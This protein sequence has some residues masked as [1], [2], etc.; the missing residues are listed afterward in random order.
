M[1]VVLLVDD[2]PTQRLY[3]TRLLQRCGAEVLIAVDGLQALEKA[4]RHRPHLILMD[5]DMPR[6]DGLLACRQLSR[7][8][9]TC[10]IPVVIMSACDL[11]ACKL[12]AMMR[13]AVDYLVKPVRSR[14]L[15]PLLPQEA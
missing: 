1:P 5:I 2:S 3:A 14:Q 6:M 8:P 13:G 7:D 12:R 10:D 15:R 9:N 4:R 11:S